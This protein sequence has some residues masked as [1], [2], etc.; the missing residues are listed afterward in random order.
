MDASYRAR[1][2]AMM[3]PVMQSMDSPSSSMPSSS[4]NGFGAN[5]LRSNDSRFM[6]GSFQYNVRIGIGLVPC[7]II[8]LGM[9]GKPVLGTLTIGLM[10]SYILDAL[11]IKHGAFFGIWASLFASQFALVLAG[12]SFFYMVSLPL[13]CLALLLSFQVNFLIGI[14]ASLQFKWLQLENPSVILALERLLFACIPF[15]ASA[16]QTWG[17][18]A[19]LGID[20]APFY[21]MVILF[22][23]YWI[24]A[25]PL[26][27]S[28]KKKP[29]KSYGGKIADEALILGALD[30][31]FHTLTLLFL[32][33]LFYMGIHH[34]HML[35]SIN[36]FCELLL[37]FFV[38]L[39]YQ[40][41]ASTRGALWW[42]AK[43]PKQF[44]QVRVVNGAI[45]IFVIIICLEIRVIFFSFGQY[46]YIPAPWSY[47]LVSIALLGG[48][49][50][51]GAFG[52]GLISDAFS[53]VLL[54]GA[55]MLA[56]LS[57]SL[58]VGLPLK[59]FPAPLVAS[60][61]LSH[62]CMKKN[63]SSYFI[64]AAT[65]SV[66][67]AWFVVHNFWFL[68]VWLG[69]LMLKS[70]CK[71]LISSAVLALAVPGL[72]LLPSKVHL[73]ADAG[74]IA[75]AILV[76]RLENR[77]H[78]YSNSYFG[79]YDDEEVVYPSYMVLLTTA[80]GLL[81]VRR[82]SAQ[83]RI[84]SLT[85]WIL[86][87]LYCSKL[88][89]F[90][91]P[92][93][94][95]LWAAAIL[96][97]AISPPV[98]L[99]RDKSKGASRMKPWQAF[100]HAAAVCISIWFCRYTLFETLQ[101]FMGRP[102]SDGLILGAILFTCAVASMPIVTYHFAHVQAAKR[103]LVLLA[104]LGA[105][106]IFLQ[107]PV[108]QAWTFWWDTYHTPRHMLDDVEIYG[109]ISEKPGW[110]LWLLIFTVVA[111]LAAFT[112][113]IPV[114]YFVELR[115]FYALGVGLSLGIYI[116]TQYFLETPILHALLVG[117]LLCCTVFLVFTHLPSA[118]SPRYMPWVFALLVALLPVSYFVEGQA[119]LSTGESEDERLV[120]LLAVEGSRASL[121]GLFASMFM[122]IAL[123]VK[124]ELASL[125]KEKVMEKGR[126]W[127]Q[128]GASSGFVPKYRLLQRR[129]S[130][131]ASFAVKKLAAEGSWMPAVGNVA[132]CL[133]FVLCLILNARL[134][135]GSNRAIFF[136]APILLLLNQDS[137]LLTGFGDRQ[138]YFPVTV[139]ISGYL[140]VAVLYKIWEEVWFSHQNS[141]WGIDTGGPGLFFVVKNALLLLVTLPNQLMFNRFMWDSLKQ[142]DMWLLLVT[143]LNLPP[144]FITDMSAIRALSLLGIIYA[145]I[146]YLVSR[147]V[148]IAG[149]K[150]I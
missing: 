68:N 90:L 56:S 18:V 142:P 117:A 123:Q 39:L 121:L 70:T 133:C 33:L 12:T 19:A 111:S 34:A 48:T 75:H 100:A 78:N 89:M 64:F 60:F 113:A 24:Y 143:P 95:A 17:F 92:A 9:G 16:V 47:L 80:V 103:A 144:L 29:E 10:L 86:T 41:Y 94:G 5:R 62:F 49:L 93:Q 104:A 96:L 129:P 37:L 14:W 38:P 77:L 32:P 65:A 119:R 45:S 128:P 3:T 72:L 85:Q 44:H 134:T 4:Y 11:H 31:A 79:G 115:L 139:S 98:L 20:H 141:S 137:S 108:P 84:N 52:M 76:C 150:F 1:G 91:L 67:V 87:C 28:F 42:L 55:M 99:Y 114:Q 126:N 51:I 13:Y 35:T 136:L 73:L 118:S 102:P 59:F 147:H 61:Y 22:G 74:L 63:I 69:G 140:V 83:Q 120:A 23:L 124:F 127:V 116:C 125:L 146:Q 82:L 58:V 135:T 122:L 106:L 25:L 43:D 88:A 66:P 7:A 54:T 26:Q 57:G 8:L 131:A 138:R 110:P 21:L 81:L 15:A 107:P 40:L 145:L 30:G 148:R 97:L 71:L 46:I 6:A 109:T 112:S 149:M 36:T 27:S 132:T 53:S 101:S 105:C 130:L 50:A 2:S